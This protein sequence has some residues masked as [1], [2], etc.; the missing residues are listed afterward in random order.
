MDSPISR[1]EG[2]FEF[3]SNFY[4]VEVL[5]DGFTYP[6]TEHAFQ[7][8]KT[9]VPGERQLI[10]SMASPG[11]A[12]KIGRTIALRPGW[13]SLRLKI[14]EDLVRQKFSRPELAEKLLATGDQE[15]IE[16]NWWN[17]FFWGVC[18]GRGENHL[19]EI[20]MKVRSDIRSSKPG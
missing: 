2:E 13:D 9:L 4:P 12:K 17:D 8:A 11:K 16:G 1:F 18:Q 14:M 6:S 10:R 5:F 3:L 7:A 15:L 20:L 19:G